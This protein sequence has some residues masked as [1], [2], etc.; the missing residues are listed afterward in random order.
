MC[1][2]DDADGRVEVFQS[3]ARKARKAHKCGECRREIPIG[4]NYHYEFGVL[5]GDRVTYK[6]CA[7]CMVAREWLN[8]NCG[9]W[10]YWDVIDEINEHAHDYRK[11]AFPLYRIV[12]GAQRHWR[13]FKGGLM[14]LPKMPPAITIHP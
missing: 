8:K 1:R 3:A 2:V 7:H 6:T 13:S 14:A 9:G 5:D 10:V 4:E 12:V 11:L